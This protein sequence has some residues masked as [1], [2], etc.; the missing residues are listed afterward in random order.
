MQSLN[1]WLSF[2]RKTCSLSVKYLFLMGKDCKKKKVCHLPLNIS[3]APQKRTPHSFTTS[4][5][6]AVPVQL[7][8]WHSINI[9]LGRR[10]W[11]RRQCSMLETHNA[12]RRVENIWKIWHTG[13]GWK[14]FLREGVVIW[15]CLLPRIILYLCLWCIY[16][17]YTH[18]QHDNP[19]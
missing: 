17:I 10:T 12:K 19:K 13:Y 6:Y 8:R 7:K 18:T 14:P 3:A 5:R 2:Y 4:G 1:L 11:R 16:H 15:K 9:I